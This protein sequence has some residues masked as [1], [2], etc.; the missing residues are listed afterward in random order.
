LEH[1][2]SLQSASDLPHPTLGS[3]HEFDPS[4]N[5][6]IISFR[7]YLEKSELLRELCHAKFYEMGFKLQG[8]E[9][10]PTDFTNVGPPKERFG[11]EAEPFEPLQ[12][13][14][15][16]WWI[17]RGF[18]NEF[19]VDML[20]FEAF[21]QDGRKVARDLINWISEPRNILEEW[22]KDM[23]TTI[24]YFAT[25][26]SLLLRTGYPVAEATNH[27]LRIFF[28]KGAGEDVYGYVRLAMNT[29]Q[30]L[31]WPLPDRL[32]PV[33]IEQRLNEM[34]MLFNAVPEKLGGVVVIDSVEPCEEA[35]T[36]K[37]SLKAGVQRQS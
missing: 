8:V 31:P 29:I 5:V 6:H 16:L 26:T 27:T 28:Q 15:H 7:D 20:M 23:L 19:Y 30:S 14:L 13:A 10:E 25:N 17:S 37:W 33:F 35:V 18:V 12:D 36:L 21:P 1:P 24:R 22:K 3:W 32:P 4:K 9:F 34:K 11:R 2:V